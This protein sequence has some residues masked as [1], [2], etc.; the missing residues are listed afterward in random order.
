MSELLGEL[1]QEL[2]L[3]SITFDV[4]REKREQ[5][6]RVLIDQALSAYNSRA[7]QIANRLQHDSYKIVTM[8]VSTTASEPPQRYRMARLMTAEADSITA[9]DMAGG[10]QVLSVRVNG[11]IELD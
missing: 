3:N 6:T 7:M 8:H 2:K 9:P 1:Q 10:D 11:T 5:Q 4:S